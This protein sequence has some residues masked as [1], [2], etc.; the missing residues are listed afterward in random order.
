MSDL[1]K[2]QHKETGLYA[3]SGPLRFPNVCVIWVQCNKEGKH[4]YMYV[5]NKDICTRCT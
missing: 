2:E 5:E 3:V 1:L 4:P